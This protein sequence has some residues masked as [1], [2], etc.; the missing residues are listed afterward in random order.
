M[1]SKSK[2]KETRDPARTRER[3]LA[4]ALTEFSA[5]GYDGARVDGIAARCR[6]SKNMLYHYF[7]S[8]EGLFIAVLE[9]MYET[10]RAR[11]RDF[12]IRGRDPV[13]AMRRLIAHTF[14]AFLEHPQAIWLLNDENM[15]K[16][17]HIRR[18]RRIRQ[19]YDPLVDTI[20]ELLRR[21]TAQGVFR[22]G[23]DPITLYVSL[24]ALAYHYL[25]N[26]YTLQMALGIDL[27]SD[28]SCRRWLAH[29]SD[30]ILLYCQ[31]DV[32]SARAGDAKLAS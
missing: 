20:R 27:A 21:G 25:S 24:S 19:L 29:I 30:M 2:R 26:R 6:L 17:R 32:R 9:R 22:S 5:K 1:R 31:R 23:I 10:L 13:V 12:S 7:G 3:I 14:E 4:Q 18:S 15:H 11:Q 8:K 28:K 16:G